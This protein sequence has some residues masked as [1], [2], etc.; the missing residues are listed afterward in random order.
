M[1]KVHLE[2]GQQEE[3]GT[4]V[5]SQQFKLPIKMKKVHPEGSLKAKNVKHVDSQQ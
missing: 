1:E 3:N 5:D 2:D 4:R